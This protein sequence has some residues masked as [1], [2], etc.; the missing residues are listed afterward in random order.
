MYPEHFLVLM[1]PFGSMT[2]D[3]TEENSLAVWY[4]YYYIEIESV[5]FCFNFCQNNDDIPMYV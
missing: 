5:M 3:I 4:H 1:P 2:G